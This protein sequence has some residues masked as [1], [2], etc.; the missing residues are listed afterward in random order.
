MAVRAPCGAARPLH[1]AMGWKGGLGASERAVLPG[2]QPGALG[3]GLSA[4][5]LL[6]G[7]RSPGGRC[8]TVRSI[9][10]GGRCGLS[11]GPLPGCLPL[12]D[13]L[14][15]PAVG[16]EAPKGCDGC[17]MGMAAV[18][19]SF[20]GGRQGYLLALGTFMGAL[21]GESA[22]VKQVTLELLLSAYLF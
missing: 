5:T 9:G 11:A 15:Q 17:R 18:T 21:L 7:V 1:G 19:S 16:K 13:L 8:C 20:G 4:L 6:R 22:L 14:E 3:L 12:G 10:W 2:G